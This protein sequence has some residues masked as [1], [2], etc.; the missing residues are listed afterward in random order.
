MW[1]RWVFR[2]ITPHHTLAWDH[3]FSDAHGTAIT[4]HPFS[5]TWPLHMHAELTFSPHPNGTQLDLTFTATP[6]TDDELTTWR[7]NQDN[8]RTGWSGTLEQLDAF[9]GG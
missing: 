4:R 2:T 3:H 5:P 6:T 9:V 7:D 1:G 8:M